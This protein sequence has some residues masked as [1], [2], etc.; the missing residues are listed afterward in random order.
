MERQPRAGDVGK[1]FPDSQRD[2]GKRDEG[3]GNAGSAGSR[4][5]LLG[6]MLEVE[7]TSGCFP[8]DSAESRSHTEPGASRTPRIPSFHRS[9]GNREGGDLRVQQIPSQIHSLHPLFLQS[10]SKPDP[11]LSSWKRESL[12]SQAG[13]GSFP[14]AGRSLE[15]K[16]LQGMESLES[17][18]AA[19]ARAEE[20]PREKQ[21]FQ[22]AMEWFGLEGTFRITQFQALPRIWWPKAAVSPGRRTGNKGEGPGREEEGEGDGQE[23]M[24]AGE[25]FAWSQIRSLFLKLPTRVPGAPEY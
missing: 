21:E 25:G 22:G 3:S 2:S 4:R 16:E 14:R 15:A 1:R 5:R 11:A 13:P 12:C 19:P 23:G 10:T 9:T 7:K 24:D 8:R 20:L 18:G 6:R 17:L